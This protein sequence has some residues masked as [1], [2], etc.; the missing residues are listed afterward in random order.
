MIRCGLTAVVAVMP[1]AAHDPITTKLTWSAEIS[2]IVYKRCVSC[3]REGASAPMPLVSFEQARPWA[4]AIKDEVLNRRMPPWGAVKGF[5]EFL[6]D[7]GLSQEEI[8]LIA[9]WVEGGAPEGNPQLLPRLPQFATQQATRHRELVFSG[10]LTLRAPAVVAG[11][12]PESVARGASVRV[13]ALRPDGGIEPMI[14]LHDFDPKLGRAYLF[15]SALRLPPRTRVRV[16]GAG[17][18]AL[19][20]DGRPRRAAVAHVQSSAASSGN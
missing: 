13:A 17:R 4:K 1:L 6:D 10:E 15:R 8:Q 16:W 20:M 3:H 12:R 5:G 14:W 18:F 19:L 11:I 7:A 2:R 9:E